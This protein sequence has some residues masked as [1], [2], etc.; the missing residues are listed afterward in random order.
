MFK[1]N[2]HILL[3][4]LFLSVGAFIFSFVFASFHPF[5]HLKDVVC[6]SKEGKHYHTQGRTDHCKEFTFFSY[7][8]TSLPKFSILPNYVVQGFF[9]YVVF[10]QNVTCLEIFNRDPPFHL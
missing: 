6:R 5:E 2:K 8:R 10:Y 3:G 4:V 9:F 7:C 1:W